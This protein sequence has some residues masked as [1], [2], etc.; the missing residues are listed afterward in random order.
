MQGSVVNHH[1]RLVAA[2]MGLGLIF[3]L[4]LGYIVGHR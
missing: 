3:G 4:M 1:H 2:A